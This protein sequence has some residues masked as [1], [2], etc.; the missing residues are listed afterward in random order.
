[1]VYV[2]WQYNEDDEV[3]IEIFST[4]EDAEEFIECNKL[5]D[6]ADITEIGW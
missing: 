3:N 6:I 5:S 4:I 2:T 1:M